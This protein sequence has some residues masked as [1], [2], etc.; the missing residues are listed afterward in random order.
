MAAAHGM[1]K[2]KDRRRAI[3]Q[4]HFLHEGL[5]VDV[6]F[7]EI[8]DMAPEGIAQQPIRK[9]LPAPVERRHREAARAQIRCGLVIF[10]D[11][12]GA[13]LE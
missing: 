11:E 13:A 9:P 12:L 10:F 3:R 2:G 7:G 1:P 6:V 4:H 5:Q 8:A